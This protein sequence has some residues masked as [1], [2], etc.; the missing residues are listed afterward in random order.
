MAKDKRAKSKNK[1]ISQDLSEYV[2]QAYLNYSMSVVLER[3]LPQLAD[4]LKPVQRRII[5]AMSE[6]GLASTAKYKKSA[7][8]IGDVLGKFHPHGD[9]A[10][11]EAMVLMAQGFSTRYPLV[12]GQGNWGS[13]DDPKSFAAMRYTEA[14]L[15]PYAQLLLAELTQ[16]I[17]DWQPNFDGTL[18]EPVLL[19]ARV[20]NLLLNG[21][22]GIAVGMATDVP[23]H[24]LA[25]VMDACCLL[26]ESPQATTAELMKVLRAPDFPCGGVIVASK[27]HLRQIYETGQGSLRARAFYA[28]KGR[29]ISI[30]S[31]PPQV[32][33]IR[34]MEQL[35]QQ[36]D[37]RKLPM[38]AELRDESDHD[39]PVSLVM[40]TRKGSDRDQLMAHLFATTDLERSVRI[41][42][43]AIAMDGKPQLQSLTGFLKDW[44]GFRRLTVKKRLQAELDGVLARLH[45]LEGLLKAYLNLD[46]VI[47]IIRSND[48]P[49]PVL[50]K[51]FKLSDKQA[52][53]ILETRLRHLARLEEKKIQAEEEDVTDKRY[54]LEKLLGSDK[55]I[56]ELLKKEFTLV[57]K[58]F[59]DERRT[60]IKKEVV[61]AQSFRPEQ[62]IGREAV[63]LV[64]SQQ[65]WVRLAKGHNIDPME[66]SYRGGDSYMCS[67]KG[68]NDMVALFMDSHGRSYSLPAL[69]L[70]SARGLGEPLSS[71]LEMA[72]GA[73]I[74]AGL[75]L[76]ANAHKSL[77]LVARNGYGF[78]AED[79]GLIAMN[80]RK[81]KQIINVKDGLGIVQPVCLEPQAEEIALLTAQNRLLILPL[82]KVPRMQKGRGVKLVNGA[83]KNRLKQIVILL[84]TT[85]LKLTDSEG[86][87]TELD[88]QDWRKFSGS[89]GNKGRSLGKFSSQ[90]RLE[91]VESGLDLNHEDAAKN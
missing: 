81:G 39:A 68:N 1:I 62:L 55:R 82:E 23:S 6:L 7:R 44:I 45:I 88:P 72:D 79:A 87:P 56:T 84:P 2:E 78:I 42:F 41:N 90:L 31:L 91:T 71:K 21:A 75:L 19:P 36:L 69:E 3:A 73:S 24:N 29:E 83:G 66:L 26:L 74:Q 17:T 40:V 70:P 9:M 59:G 77:L 20:P 32:S 50:M 64:V 5:Y 52:E 15:T 8:T 25:E 61:E 76:A 49:K 14:R 38:V 10:C 28:V 34:V 63:T 43:N 46:V 60:L 16:D 12:D 18:T 53:S 86:D 47:R 65:G 67:W 27:D 37:N 80:R 35:Q 30:T 11:Y 22:S 85:I 54:M 48:K 13:I 58:E 4:G 33:T 89:R 51:K 57:K